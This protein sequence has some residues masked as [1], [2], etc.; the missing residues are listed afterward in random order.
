MKEKKYMYSMDKTDND[1]DDSDDDDDHVK[2]KSLCPSLNAQQEPNIWHNTC[3]RERRRKRKWR[4][5]SQSKDITQ[6][7]CSCPNLKLSTLS[8]LASFLP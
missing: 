2:W 6:R 5:N 1:D 3:L 8:L 4:I 7:K